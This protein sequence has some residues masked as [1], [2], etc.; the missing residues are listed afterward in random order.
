MFN[1]ANSCDIDVLSELVL[2]KA[3]HFVV[4]DVVFNWLH[5]LGVDATAA[6]LM[7]SGSI[8]AS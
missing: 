1:D 3:S 6:Y 7:S 4:R 5:G 2:R 8:L